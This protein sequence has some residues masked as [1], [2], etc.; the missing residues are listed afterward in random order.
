MC[1]FIR[2]FCKSFSENTKQQL[3][4]DVFYVVLTSRLTVDQS[5]D[6]QRDHNET[7]LSRNGTVLSNTHKSYQEYS[8]VRYGTV[9]YG[10]VRYGTVRYGTV[11]YG[12]VRYG[13]VPYRTVPYN[14]VQ[15]CTKQYNTTQY[16][17]M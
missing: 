6:L 16:N 7:L 5:A 17:T 9:R 3:T 4:R 13:T 1:I 8:T 14:T 15:Y 10:T 12:T 11:R 2:M